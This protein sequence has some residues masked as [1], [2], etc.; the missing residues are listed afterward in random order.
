MS[1]RFDIITVAILRN[2][3]RKIERE[4]IMKKLLLFIIIVVFVFTACKSSGGGDS[5]S[6]PAGDGSPAGQENT[7]EYTPENTQVTERILFEKDKVKTTLLSLEPGLDSPLGPEFKILVENGSEQSITLQTKDSSVN[8]IM[9]GTWLSCEVP[10]GEKVNDSITF[11]MPELEI[12][13]IEII[14]E[15]ELKLVVIDTASLNPLFSTDTITIATSAENYVQSCDDSGTIALDRD[16]IKIVTK[17]LDDQDSLWG[18]DVFVYIENNSGADVIVQARNVLVNGFTIDP[19][20]SCDVLGGKKAFSTIS[21][22]ET[23]LE[24]YGISKISEIELKFVVIDRNSFDTI[25]EGDIV[26]LA[27]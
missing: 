7:Q 5:D 4:S 27:F 13:G 22:M 23:D 19:W 6:G 9:I 21:F 2:K 10:P 15:V 18:A 12:S 20:F 24:A 8:G 25:S 11:L 26:K 17:K 16:G 14:K 1:V 3:G